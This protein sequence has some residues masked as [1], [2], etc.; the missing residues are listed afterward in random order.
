MIVGMTERQKLQFDSDLSKKN[1]RPFLFSSETHYSA[2][3]K[4]NHLSVENVY[5]WRARYNLHL[6]TN[7][8]LFLFVL[9]LGLILLEDFVNSYVLYKYIADPLSELL[10]VVALYFL[11]GGWLPIIGAMTVSYLSFSTN[12]NTRKQKYLA[13]HQV[14]FT[15]RYISHKCVPGIPFCTSHN[16]N[17][18]WSCFNLKVKYLDADGEIRTAYSFLGN[19]FI[20][21][22]MCDGH[23]L[24]ICR[25]EG[26]FGRTIDIVLIPWFVENLPIVI[27]NDIWTHIENL[28]KNL[29]D[30]HLELQEAIENIDNDD[31]LPP[32]DVDRG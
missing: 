30:L 24:T 12:S 29:D 13:E 3:A 5:H 9:G 14:T 27:P 22:T 23:I 10:P 20:F 25:V 4:A 16:I 28:N 32:V 1:E 21:E 17:N 11:F 2:C 7:I 31:Y 6:W 18:T 19:K 26:H 15:G 8:G